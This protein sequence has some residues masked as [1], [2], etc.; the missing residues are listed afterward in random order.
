MTEQETTNLVETERVW[1]ERII[2][3]VDNPPQCVDEMRKVIREIATH[4]PKAAVLHAVNVAGVLAVLPTVVLLAWAKVVQD[5]YTG[6]GEIPD[7]IA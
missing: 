2:T 3:K 6:D 7:P 1:C 4:P 5:W